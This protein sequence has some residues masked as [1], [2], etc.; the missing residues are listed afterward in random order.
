[1]EADRRDGGLVRF[2]WRITR[3]HR[4][5]CTSLTGVSNGI[6]VEIFPNYERDPMW[7]DLPLEQPAIRGD[8]IAFPTGRAS[9]FPC[10]RKP[11]IG[12]E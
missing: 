12:G 1:M 11:S 4:S 8:A 7:F 10:A 9:G 2:V 5:P 3:S 6:C